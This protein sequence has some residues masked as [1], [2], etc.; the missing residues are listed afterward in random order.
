MSVYFQGRILVSDIKIKFLKVFSLVS[1]QFKEHW[2]IKE[3]PIF[4]NF[5]WKRHHVVYKGPK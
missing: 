3:L 5:N 4:D 2:F 1:N